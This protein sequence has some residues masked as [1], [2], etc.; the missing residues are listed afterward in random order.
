MRRF[1]SFLIFSFCLSFT[2]QNFAQ[3][4]SDEIGYGDDALFDTPVFKPSNVGFSISDSYKNAGKKPASQKQKKIDYSLDKNQ[5]SEIGE[6][7]D[8]M[9]KY[10]DVPAKPSNPKKVISYKKAVPSKTSNYKKSTT[11]KKLPKSMQKNYENKMAAKK[12]TQK[13]IS[14]SKS[15]AK[16]IKYDYSKIPKN[17]RSKYGDVRI[18]FKPGISFRR[19][20]RKAV[21]V[22]D[23]GHGGKDPG[24]IGGAGTKEKDITLS[25]SLAIKRELEKSGRYKVVLTRSKDRY[26]KLNNRVKIARRAG[27]D[28]MISV[29]AD[30]HRNKNTR[31]FSIYTISKRRALRE[32]KKLLKKADYEEV[33]RGVQL[34][35]ESSDVK[36]AIID[37]AQKETK[38]V[39][40]EFSKILAKHLGKR[41][42]PLKRTNREASLAVLTGADI[43][44]VLLELGYLSNRYE[45]RLLRKKSHQAALVRSI[46]SAINEYFTTYE[47][48]LE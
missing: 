21:I 22:I 36:E 34:K 44:S 8:S 28:V 13:P 43:P 18:D 26:V 14:K 42:K 6:L 11:S 4:T 46:S 39:S 2:Q 16:N 24:A 17:I 32:A 48:L 25:Y 30:S 35:G 23:P 3:N 12:S 9:F 47:Y 31:G 38:D 33:V 29:H 10:D 37:F 5:E 27:G 19:E 15:S 45:E 41:A 40:D 1:F 20:L 7:V